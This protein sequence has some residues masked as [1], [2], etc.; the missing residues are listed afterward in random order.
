M[1]ACAP[2]DGSVAHR[3]V[4][5]CGVVCVCVCVCTACLRY[6]CDPIASTPARAMFGGRWNSAL[7]M[8]GVL[9]PP[10]WR[11]SSQVETS[12]LHQGRRPRPAGLLVCQPPCRA[13]AP[14]P[15]VMP[16]CTSPSRPGCRVRFLFTLLPSCAFFPRAQWKALVRHHA[17]LVVADRH[18]APRFER[19]CYSYLPPK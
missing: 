11:K 12:R 10:R 3:C 13:L 17:Q 19:E 9:G 8:P 7:Y 6:W 14:C 1:N 4:V 5:W 18:L 15:A 2:E 16:V